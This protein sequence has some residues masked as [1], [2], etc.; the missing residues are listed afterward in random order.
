MKDTKLIHLNDDW[1]FQGDSLSVTLYRK[2]VSE[3]TGKLTLRPKGY[4]NNVEQM[5]HRLIDLDLNACTS[6]ELV[7]DRINN[8][9]ADIEACFLALCEGD[10]EQLKHFIKP[11]Y[12]KERPK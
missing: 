2:K 11:T 7:V 12:K 5:F 8:L 10:A 4:F 3:K 9:K 1:A 6:L